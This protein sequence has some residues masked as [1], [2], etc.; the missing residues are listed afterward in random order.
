M[1]RAFDVLI[2]ISYYLEI[3]EVVFGGKMHGIT[4]KK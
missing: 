2:E 4:A 3:K 1:L